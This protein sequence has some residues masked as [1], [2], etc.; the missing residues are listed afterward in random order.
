MNKFYYFEIIPN[1]HQRSVTFNV[2]DNDEVIFNTVLVNTPSNFFNY[3]VPTDNPRV[4]TEFINSIS[5][6]ETYSA[7]FTGTDVE[8]ILTYV[9]DGQ[10]EIR[11]TT[12][13]T[14]FSS[15]T[16]FF[17]QEVC[18]NQFKQQLSKLIFGETSGLTAIPSLHDVSLYNPV[19][20]VVPVTNTDTNVDIPVTNTDTN[21]DIPVTNTNNTNTN[22]NA[23]VPPV[24]AGS[25]VEDDRLVLGDMD[26]LSDT[27]M[28]LTQED[29]IQLARL[30]KKRANMMIPP[31]R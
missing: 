24:L 1:F 27:S 25:V 28:Y 3:P 8:L 6:D 19:S 29:M 4:I 5:S 31:R 16:S 9:G 14:S 2:F 7:T 17:V 21:T 20:N 30:E 11:F 13:N 15:S 12:R 22:T 10:R 18:T 23:D 26:Q